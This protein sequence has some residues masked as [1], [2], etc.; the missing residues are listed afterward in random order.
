[1]GISKG[2]PSKGTNI[3]GKTFISKSEKDTIAFSKEFSKK[4][5]KGDVVFLVGD[6][7]T[8]KTTFTK[9]LAKGLGVKRTV[10]SSSFLLANEYAG[11]KIKLY[12]MDL[13]RLEGQSIEGIGL[14]EY[15]FGD[16]VCVIEWADKIKK[17]NV[18]SG[19]YIYIDWVDES[20]RKIVIRSACR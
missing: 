4:L 8:G 5:K 2:K 12:H 1:M 6:L 10:K 15:I 17:V 13:Y 18:P 20:K 16:G 9:G 19:Y 7:G 14:E 3:L 11:T